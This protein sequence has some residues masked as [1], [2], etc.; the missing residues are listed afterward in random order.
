MVQAL[1]KFTPSRPVGN[2]GVECC[3]QE[4]LCLFAGVLLTSVPQELKEADIPRQDVLAEAPKH[5]QIG[6]R[7]ARAGASTAVWASALCPGTVPVESTGQ[8]G[9]GWPSYTLESHRSQTA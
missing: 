8:N 7:A 6:R 4:Q 2:G 9:S 1:H 5:P 3:P